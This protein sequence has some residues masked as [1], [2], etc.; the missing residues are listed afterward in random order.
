MSKIIFNKDKSITY[1]GQFKQINNHQ[2]KLIFTDIIPD[3]ESLVSGFNLVNEHNGMI[4]TR[5][6]DYTTLFQHEDENTFILSNDGS[7]YVKPIYTVTFSGTNCALTGETS[8][9]V[10]NFEDLV[11]PKVKAVENYEFTG[12]SPEIPT[13][14]IVD[15]NITFHTQTSYVQPLDE[16]KSLKK[17]EVGTACEQIIFAGVDVQIGEN[18]EH[19][20]LQT[21]DQLNLFRKQSQLLSGITNLE[22]HQD[23]HPCK[24]YT[25]EEM[26]LIIK[27]AMEHVSYHTTYCNS[28]NMW[29]A[30]AKT[31]DEV[32]TIYYGAQ[33]PEEYQSEVLKDYIEKMKIEEA[34]A[35][36][37]AADNSID[38]M[39]KK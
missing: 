8:Q 10:E 35:N 30:G 23:G 17:A 26:Q 2:V 13:S 15:K 19:F 33:V 5:R 20:S 1:D 14:G 29:I 3:N 38:N 34:G 6:E 28:L 9:T 37:N 21:N 36:E 31:K 22:Y 12:W 4:Q 7:V 24:Y 16:V 27:A 11:V 18:I 39:M 25:A 32:N